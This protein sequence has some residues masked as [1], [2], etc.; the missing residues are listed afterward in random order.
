MSGENGVTLLHGDARAVLA[1]LPAESVHMIVTS[2]PYYALRDYGVEGQIGLENSPAEYLETMVDVFREV[3]RVLRKDG[4]AA[5]NMGDCYVCSPNGRSAADTKALGRDDRTFRDKPWA[6]FGGL[7]PKNLMMMPSRMAIALQADGWVLRSMIPWLKR[8]AMPC[9]ATDRPGA[10]IEYVFIFSRSQRYFWDAEA[11]RRPHSITSETG[12]TYRRDGKDYGAAVLGRKV[13]GL[14]KEGATTYQNPNG[15]NLRNS[16]FYFDSLDLAIEAARSELAHLLHLREKGGLLLDGEGEPLALDVNPQAL[17]DA[18]F[19]S[20]PERLVAP[21]ILAGTSEWGC[22]AGCGAPWLRVV[23]KGE[24]V[25]HHWAPG[26]QK[27]AHIAQGPHGKTSVLHTGMIAPNRTTGWQPSCK[28]G[29]TE[30]QPCVVL[31]PF[32]GSGT[33]SLVASKL[34]RRSIAIELSQE[35]GRIFSKRNQQLGLML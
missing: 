33:T 5:V 20:F 34:G 21:L 18:H 16:D 8:S 9:S 25:Q 12:G 27:K 6:N 2:P 24:P 28:C 31:D 14:H 13:N 30:G 1:T 26:T 15:R 17:A 32:A 4:I 11:V 22:C 23:E 29:T 35:Y 7:A 19:A 10:A 3:R